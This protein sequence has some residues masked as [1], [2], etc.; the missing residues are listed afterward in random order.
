MEVINLENNVFL[1]EY[2]VNNV[3]E[4][5]EA[6]P[7]AESTP[8]GITQIK[9]DTF[10]ATETTKGQGIKI[11]LLDTGCDI[12][13][14]DLAGRIVEFKNFTPDDAGIGHIVTDN[15]G[16]G[17]HVAGTVAAN[18]NTEG[19]VGVAPNASLYIMKVLTNG[20][21]TVTAIKNALIHCINKNVDIINMSLGT[22]TNDPELEALIKS[23]VRQNIMVVVSAGNTGDGSASTDEVSYPAAYNNSI[24][25]GA[26]DS[27][28]APS[29][30]TNSNNQI[31]IV[32]PGV[33]IVSTYP[34]NQYATL[35]G[36]SM[37]AP[38]VTGALALLKNWAKAKFNRS[39]TETELYGYLIKR[40]L[41]SSH[42]VKLIGN[43]MV[44]LTADIELRNYIT[45]S[46][47]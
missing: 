10:W 32:A 45:G 30:F 22:T 16:H 42:D 38:H 4:T 33:S 25:V 28:R 31:D 47:L 27:T 20:G 23:A 46:G 13:H 8:Y 3:Y 1:C 34:N 41:N 29:S 37:A 9:A 18:S 5:S 11:A 15:V 6:I 12:N 17:T 21:G 14:P 39:F 26:V 35:S 24:A 40:T 43:G 7:N 44:Y 36:T 19:V 2:Q